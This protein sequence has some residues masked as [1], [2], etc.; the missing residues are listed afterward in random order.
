[1]IVP[2]ALEAGLV[3]GRSDISMIVSACVLAVHGVV[4]LFLGAKVV[5]HLKRIDKESAIY[6]LVEGLNTKT[7]YFLIYHFDFFLI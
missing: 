5:L 6:T 3:R 7:R 4:L 1:M 2:F